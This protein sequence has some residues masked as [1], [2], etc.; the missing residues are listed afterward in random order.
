VQTKEEVIAVVR[1]EHPKYA[2]LSDN[3]LY[4]V[5]VYVVDAFRSEFPND[6]KL[7][8]TKLYEKHKPFSSD[9]EEMLLEYYKD[10]KVY[11]AELSKEMVR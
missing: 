9:L 4:E 11:K 8:D 1:K 10:L 2:K 3:D 6:A 5:L 7:P